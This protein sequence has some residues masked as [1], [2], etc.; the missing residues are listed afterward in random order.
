MQIVEPAKADGA[1]INPLASWRTSF[2]ASD[3]HKD[4]EATIAGDDDADFVAHCRKR[5]V[6]PAHRVLDILSSLSGVSSDEGVNRTEETEDHPRLGETFSWFRYK[7]CTCGWSKFA[8]DLCEIRRG[9]RDRSER[10]TVF[11]EGKCQPSLV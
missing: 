4:R 9:S 5:S 11:T 2:T 6:E 1:V 3:S 8:E 7:Q 10:S